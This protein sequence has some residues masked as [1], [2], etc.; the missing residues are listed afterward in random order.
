MTATRLS[1]PAPLAVLFDASGTS[2]DGGNAFHQ[3]NYEFNFG[4][5]RGQTWAPSGQPKNVQRGGPL[6]A[7]V[8]EVPGTYTVRVRASSTDANAETTVTITVDNPDTVYNGA[9]TVCVSVTANYAGCPSGAVQQTSLP[10]S[11]DGKRV[12]LRRGETFPAVRVVHADDNV[13]VGAFGSG[14]KPRVA[15]VEIGFGRPSVADFPDD[16]TIMDLKVSQGIFQE[17]SGSRMLFLRND[18]DDADTRANNRIVFGQLL[19]YWAGQDPYRQ[20]APSAFYFPRELFLVENRIL[21]TSDGDDIPGHNVTAGGSRMAILGN[22]IGRAFEHNIRL[23]SA[24]K[25]IISHNTVL[26]GSFDGSRHPLKLHSG[27]L[28]P[29]ADAYTATSGRNATSQVLISYNNM[30]STSDNNAWTVAIRP[31]NAAA[32]SGEGIEDVIVE[33]NRFTRGT[34][35]NTDLLMV[36]R[37]FTARGNTRVDGT[38]SIGT[39]S[40]VAYPNLP[41]DWRGPYWI[42]N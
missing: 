9:R 36:G 2:V 22:E 17:S 21:G 29:Y 38:M 5:D 39:E 30:G 33:N 20:V 16:I 8:F 28:L 1:G 10:A 6:A 15:T 23:Y 3:L 11:L 18:L 13:Q 35:T 14:A 19:N 4:D 24:H 37:R 27:G 12:L 40:G 41:A 25:S 26:G 31:Q 34:R 32:E 7:H 42:R